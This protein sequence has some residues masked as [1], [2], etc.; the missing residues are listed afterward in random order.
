MVYFTDYQSQSNMYKKLS[1]TKDAVNEVRIDSI[2]K[3]LS[4]LHAPR[5]DVFMIEENEKIIDI[6]ERILYFN[7]L[8]Q[9]GQ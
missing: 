6:A 5:D 7:H 8:N 3:L 2:K 9:S 4:K 1:E